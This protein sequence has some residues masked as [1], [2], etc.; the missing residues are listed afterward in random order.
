MAMKAMTILGMFIK[1]YSRIVAD[2]KRKENFE[3]SAVKHWQ[4][5]LVLNSELLVCGNV[6]LVWPVCLD[7]F[8]VV[9][10]LEKS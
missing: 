4:V 7:F 6:G 8:L 9:G 1:L 2:S 5:G 10:F 3:G